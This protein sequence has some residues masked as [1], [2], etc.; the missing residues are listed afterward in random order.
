MH[1]FSLLF[2]A[3]AAW[4][5]PALRHCLTLRFELV[6][7]LKSQRALIRVPCRVVVRI[8]VM[9]AVQSGDGRPASICTLRVCACA[10]GLGMN[11]REWLAL[12]V[13][14]PCVEV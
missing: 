8:A 7:S 10:T 4:S 3:L 11:A 5:L 14:V 2:Q 9:L 1:F 13:H 12:L 6:P